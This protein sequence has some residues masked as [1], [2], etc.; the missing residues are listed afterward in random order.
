MF[1]RSERLVRRL[2]TNCSSLCSSVRSMRIALSSFYRA[3]SVTRSNAYL[4][5]VRRDTRE[6]WHGL[7]DTARN[8]THIFETR[9]S[10]D[11]LSTQL[12]QKGSV[13]HNLSLTNLRTR[14]QHS[15][16][17][18]TYTC[19]LDSDFVSRRSYRVASSCVR[20][21]E[22]SSSQREEEEGNSRDTLAL[23]GSRRKYPPS[24]TYG[25][26]VTCRTHP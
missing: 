26:G 19:T 21:I 25:L 1:G 18:R 6:G 15:R 13:P 17:A 2:K 24:L 5:F 23:S 7:I 11:T 16:T 9:H 3:H 20:R 4:Q 8:I 14:I 10:R 12:P 22:P